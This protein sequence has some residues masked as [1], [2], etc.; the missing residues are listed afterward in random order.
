MDWARLKPA[1]KKTVT[2]AL[3][4][5][6]LFGMCA[7]AAQDLVT[8]KVTVYKSQIK[9]SRAQLV[10][11]KTK[12][13]QDEEIADKIESLESDEQRLSAQIESLEKKIPSRFNMAQLVGEFTR[14][15]KEVKLES[16]KQR[17]VKDQ[18]YSRIFL[19][20]K[21]YSTYLNAVKYLASVESI[22]PFL[23]VEEM[24]MAIL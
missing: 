22:S 15:A 16:V 5:F 1:E 13:P 3:A 8:K 21:F 18:G 4:G 11:L 9:K 17:I 12:T 20:V 23:K 6:L 10:D 14:L 19:E 2:I 24:E 7:K